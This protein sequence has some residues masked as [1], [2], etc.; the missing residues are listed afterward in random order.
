MLSQSGIITTIIICYYECISLSTSLSIETRPLLS[1]KMELQTNNYWRLNFPQLGSYNNNIIAMQKVRAVIRA[2]IA[3]IL[4][5]A[6]I[7]IILAF[8]RQ[9]SFRQNWAPIYFWSN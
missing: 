7:R 4:V 8:E 9:R 2:L 5:R 1:G 3:V 6:V